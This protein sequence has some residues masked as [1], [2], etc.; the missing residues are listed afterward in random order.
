MG[1]VLKLRHEDDDDIYGLRS[2]SRRPKRWWGL[3]YKWEAQVGYVG[4]TGQ[5][6]I[7]SPSPCRA[8]SS[9]HTSV[10][11]KLT[12]CHPNYCYRATSAC[13]PKH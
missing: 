10:R 4:A 13:F 8:R 3:T 5:V 2:P 6:T 1:S 9:S 7:L 12:S 11:T